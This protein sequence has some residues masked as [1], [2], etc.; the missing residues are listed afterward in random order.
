MTAVGIL[1]GTFDPIHHGHLRLA[2]EMAA[3]LELAAVRLLPLHTPPH[4]EPPISSPELRLRM[5]L[6]AIAGQKTLLADDRELKR[7]GISYTVDT[8]AEFRREDAEIPLCLILGMD[9]FLSLPSWRHWEQIIDLAHIAVAHR[10]DAGPSTPALLSEFLDRHRSDDPKELHRTRAG[11][12]YF[13]AL[14]VLEISASGI[15]ERIA[16][17]ANVHFLLPEPVLQLIHRHGLYRTANPL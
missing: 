8:L 2:L 6:A 15:R 17:G 7:Q 11:R 3:A 1:G 4:R 10:L 16:A 5:L 13:A 9:A 14:P 12:V